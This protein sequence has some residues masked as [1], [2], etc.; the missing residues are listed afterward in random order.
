AAQAAYGAAKTAVE[1]T[2]IRAPFAGVILSKHVDIGDVLAP[3]SSTVQSKGAVVS[4]ADLDTLE[5][6]ADV[7]ESN[8]LKIHLGQACEIQ[9][10]ALPDQRFRS[11]VNRIV[12]T[13]DRTKATVLVKVRF[14]DRDS[15]IL[16]D[17]SAKVAFLSRELAP[18]QQQPVT[19]V[20]PSALV[21]R[22]QQA[23]VFLVRG[24]R[25]HETPVEAGEQLGDRT[26][27][28]RGLKPGDE[29]VLSPPEKLK[30]GARIKPART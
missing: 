14:V 18:D 2:L 12:P 28:D 25:V 13:V 1:Y 19:V 10:D 20:Q 21:S 26:V 29:V 27:I 7:S 4:M 24:D 23:T 17:M 22:R 16:P 9:L 3:F 5:V 8:L 6:E 30:D 15:R 11:R